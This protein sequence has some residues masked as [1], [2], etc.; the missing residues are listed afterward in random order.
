MFEAPA[1]KPHA[2]P[3]SVPGEDVQTNDG[4]LGCAR[5]YGGIGCHASCTG[6]AG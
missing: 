4:L 2:L 6:M 3:E 5:R 1:V